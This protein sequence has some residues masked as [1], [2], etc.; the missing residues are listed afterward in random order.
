MEAKDV[1]HIRNLVLRNGDRVGSAMPKNIAASPRQANAGPVC[2]ICGD[3]G[4]KS[5]QIGAEKRVTRCDCTTVSRTKHL[6]EQA[7]FPPRYENCDLASYE[8]EGAQPWGD[9][10]QDGCRKVYC[11]LSIGQDW[12]AVIGPSGAG[13]THLSVAILKQLIVTKGIACLFVIIA[14][15]LSR[16]RFL[17]SFGAGYGIRFTSSGFSGRGTRAG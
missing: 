6:I 16:F 11:E 8:T 4:W 2:A 13:K 5:V 1:R 3:T 12:F 15:C 9:C 10:G 14:S 7:K 17:Q